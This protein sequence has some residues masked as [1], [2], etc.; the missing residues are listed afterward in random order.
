MDCTAGIQ[1]V[2][3]PTVNKASLKEGNQLI[4]DSLKSLDQEAKERYKEKNPSKLK[5][6]MG[7]LKLHYDTKHFEK[8]QL[9]EAKQFSKELKKAN[10]K[11]DAMTANWDAELGVLDFSTVEHLDSRNGH[12]TLTLDPKPEIPW[13]EAEKLIDKDHL[14]KPID[15]SELIAGDFARWEKVKKEIA[16]RKSKNSKPTPTGGYLGETKY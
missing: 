2:K 12:Y 10:R 7:R 14:S 3:C 8:T 11:V 15:I 6:F 16:A 4:L 1:M 5:Q 9:K 13:E